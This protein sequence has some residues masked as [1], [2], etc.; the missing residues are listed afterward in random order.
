V[1]PQLPA[2]AGEKQRLFAH[3]SHDFRRIDLGHL[4][5][6]HSSSTKP[7]KSLTLELR[8]WTWMQT[9]WSPWP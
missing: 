4:H 8:H 9:I 7:Y 1:F 6:G 2:P 5:S 3:N